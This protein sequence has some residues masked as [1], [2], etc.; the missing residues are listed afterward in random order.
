MRSSVSGMI[1]AT[2]ARKTC[3][4]CNAQQ[5]AAIT[6]LF[7]AVF[8]TWQPI[9]ALTD[10][11]TIVD[12]KMNASKYGTSTSVPSSPHVRWTPTD[13]ILD[14]DRVCS[15]FTRNPGKAN[16]PFS[17]QCVLP[18]HYHSPTCACGCVAVRCAT[19]ESCAK[20]VAGVRQ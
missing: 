19:I 20:R 17:A 9:G 6:D 14:K 16:L 12:E 11:V 13:T 5:V 8:F 3:L 7:P 4:F 2:V 15:T 18:C 1:K 10:A